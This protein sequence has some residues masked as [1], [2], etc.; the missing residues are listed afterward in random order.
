MPRVLFVHHRPQASG[1]VRSLALLISA[2]D[3]RWEPHVLVPAGDAAV[4]AA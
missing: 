2:L 1:A 4:A 3:G